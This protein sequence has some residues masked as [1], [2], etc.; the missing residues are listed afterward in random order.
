MIRSVLP[1][2]V[3]RCVEHLATGER[4]RIEDVLLV[5]GT[6][7]VAYATLHDNDERRLE[8]WDE[9]EAEVLR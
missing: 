5:P 9:G 1:S 2:L 4:R 3:G 7:R 8:V 6:A